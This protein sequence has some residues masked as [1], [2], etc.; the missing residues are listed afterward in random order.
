MGFTIILGNDALKFVKGLIDV[1]TQVQPVGVDLTVSKVFKFISSARLGF[2]TRELPSL[3]EIPPKDGGWFLSQGV[4]KV[5]FSEV[6]EVPEDVVAFCFP[7][8]SLL[9][10]GIQLTCT[11]WDPGYVGRGEALLQV[12]NPYGIFLEVYARVAQLVFFK[13]PKK[14][15]KAYDGFYKGENL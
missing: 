5:R 13:L 10:S 6:V 14:V 15:V 8:S 1:N 2:Q 12:F 7:R 3:E 11:V 9:R 4:Y